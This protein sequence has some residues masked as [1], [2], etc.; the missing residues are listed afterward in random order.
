[1]K[2]DKPAPPAHHGA[3]TIADVARA[4]GTDAYLAA[5]DRWA[6]STWSAYSELHEVARR[7][8]DAAVA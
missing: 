7:W 1:M 2:L 8:I 6:R 3:L 4:E 5:L